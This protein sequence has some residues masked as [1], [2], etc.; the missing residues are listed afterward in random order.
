MRVLAITIA[1]ICLFSATT[2]SAQR[3]I[4]IATVYEID[5][6][7]LGETR[8]IIVSLPDGYDTTVGERGT[9]LSGGQKQRICIA[10]AILKNPKVLV[11]DEATSALDVESEQLVQQ[12]L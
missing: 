5:S 2:A 6:A 1:S 12:A 4:S 7:T 10:R 8:D 9:L 11:L 3:Q